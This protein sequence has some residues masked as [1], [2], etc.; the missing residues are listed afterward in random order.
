MNAITQPPQGQPSAAATPAGKRSIEALRGDRQRPDPTARTRPATNGVQVIPE[1]SLPSISVGF[2]NLQS[3][4]FTQ[5]VARALASST[6]VPTQYRMQMP[7]PRNRS[8]TIDNPN[9]IPNC[10]VALNI[11][12]RVREDVLMVMQN[13]HVIE[14]RPSWGAPYVIGRVNSCGEFSRLKFRMEDRGQKT[15]E[16]TSYEWNSQEKKKV[17]N[18]TKVPI[19]DI[20]CTAYATEKAT[21][22]V[23]EGDTVSIEMAVQ[24]G[25]YSKNGSKWRTMAT[26]ML[27]YR[28]GSFF[29]RANCPDIL[30]G[31]RTE[32][33]EYDVIDAQQAGD[34]Q[35]RVT[36]DIDGVASTGGAAG[37]G[38]AA[39]GQQDEA[40]GAE[41]QQ[42]GEEST[43]A[44]DAQGGA[45]EAVW[46][47]QSEGTTA[48]GTNAGD[49]AN[50]KAAT[51]D[52]TAREGGERPAGAPKRRGG[53]LDLTGAG[54][55]RTE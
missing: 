2:G 44:S 54:F 41:A 42:D 5:R 23:L 25:W 29:A 13:M 34:G 46:A 33:E 35:W 11:A 37:T 39:S 24:E 1:L 6:M 40:P 9:A 16:Y 31:M 36:E 55:G 32:D 19:H 38:S 14:G 30:M 26:T 45:H 3:W 10:I 43:D 4:E 53:Q 7:N 8:E 12:Q 51:A 22:E 27:R 21:G 18:T 48:P 52:D 20:A 47:T 50:G 28:A 49:N 17:A 15:V